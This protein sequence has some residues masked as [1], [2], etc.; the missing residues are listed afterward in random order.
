MVKWVKILVH[1]HRHAR[2]IP[3]FFYMSAQF[4]FLILFYLGA[5]HT[6]SLDS[7]FFPFLRIN[8]KSVGKHR[9]E[10][11]SQPSGHHCPLSTWLPQLCPHFPSA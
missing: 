1:N 4:L 11:V 7:W 8:S 9:T 2:N 3:L 6:I 10:T 5:E